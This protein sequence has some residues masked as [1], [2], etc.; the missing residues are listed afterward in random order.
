MPNDESIESFSTPLIVVIGEGS[1]DVSYLEPPLKAYY[2]KKFGIKCKLITISDVTSDPNYSDD[3]LMALLPGFIEG[4]LKRPIN[5]IDKNIAANI[6]EII[7]IIDIDEA[8]ID[9]SLIKEN[10]DKKEFFYTNTGIEYKNLNAVKERNQRKQKRVDLLRATTTVN[11][12]GYDIP[13]SFLFFSI[14]IDDFHYE[15]ALNWTKEE[16]NRQAALFARRN[17]YS[18]D[19]DEKI[20]VFKSLF[21]KNPSNFPDDAQE[22][23][24]YVSKDN[25]CLKTCSNVIHKIKD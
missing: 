6:K 8:F 10:E 25:N 19:D 20:E 21:K 1:S 17:Y 24:D 13:Y 3:Q 9:D 16:K 22:A 5:K 7:Q 11:V 18:K 23:W 15:N 12:F 4:E 2:S 14:N